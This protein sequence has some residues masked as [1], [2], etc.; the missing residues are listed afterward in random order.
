MRLILTLALLFS[1]SFAEGHEADNNEQKE[2]GAIEKN[3]VKN[4]K[5]IALP[6]DQLAAYK[7]AKS[8]CLKENKDLKPIELKDCII[9]KI[10]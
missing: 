2:N 5:S 8:S 7:A 1:R 9:S 10:K 4:E 6:S 3:E